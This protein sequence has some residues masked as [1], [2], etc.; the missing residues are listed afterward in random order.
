M[1][2][3]RD[4]STDRPF[5]RGIEVHS[6]RDCRNGG[7]S[8]GQSGQSVTAFAHQ[9]TGLVAHC[10]H[11]PA[12]ASCSMLSSQAPRRVVQNGCRHRS[13][14]RTVVIY[15]YWRGGSAS[16]AE[17]TGAHS[18]RR[19]GVAHQVVVAVAGEPAPVGFRGE[20]RV[21]SAKTVFA[22]VFAIWLA[23][24]ATSEWRHASAVKRPSV[25]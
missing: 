23:P 8:I 7:S 13:N 4:G 3:I 14:L 24:G 5:L 10:P 22:G 16:L 21:L 6:A 20:R 25:F 17:M 2:R 18:P 9:A 19:F 1:P 11:M 15:R 12:E